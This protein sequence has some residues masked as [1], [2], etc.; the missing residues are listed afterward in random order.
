MTRLE[1]AAGESDTAYTAVK[2]AMDLI[3]SLAGLL[4]MAILYLPIAVAIK[5]DS[6][7]PVLFLSDRAGLGGR[8]FRVCKF[9]TMHVTSPVSG[10]KPDV[11]DE[12]VTA[13]GRFLRRTSLDEL[14]QCYNILR[15]E[16]SLVGPRPE[17]VAFLSRYSDP[18][19]RRFDVKP[20]LTGWWQ[21]NGRKQPMYEHAAEDVYYVDHQSIWLDL[22]ILC[23]TIYA[24]V[25]GRGAV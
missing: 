17:Q 18:H 15:G 22:S 4:V 11:D 3:G 19:R 14:P 20:G 2:R 10:H 23:R 13:V 6:P 9:R 7:G 16:M 8:L 1:A 5:L 24:V 21:V 25:N 12:R